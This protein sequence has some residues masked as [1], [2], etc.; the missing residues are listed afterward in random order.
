MTTCIET[1]SIRG[2]RAGSA[3]EHEEEI[4]QPSA[5]VVFFERSSAAA[6]TVAQTFGQAPRKALNET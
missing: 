6:D 5:A 3:V 2:R 1:E 4:A